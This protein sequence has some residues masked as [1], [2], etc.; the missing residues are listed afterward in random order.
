M[1]T[2]GSPLRLLS[3]IPGLVRLSNDYAHASELASDDLSR[4]VRQLRSADVVVIDDDSRKLMVAALLRPFSRFRLVSVDLVLRRP[5]SL[6]SA[7]SGR[8]KR[9]LLRQVDRFVL[10]FRNVGPF[11]TAYGIAPARTAYVPF[12]VN[13]WEQR[14]DWPAPV[15]PGDY[16]LCAGRSQR[17]VNTFIKA[18]SLVGCP[19]V[20]ANGTPEV[21]TPLPPNVH[22]VIDPTD[23]LLS[24]LAHMARARII[25]IPRFR[26][27]LVASGIST[28]LMAMALG[29]PVILSSGP[30]AEDVLQGEA[31]IVPAEDVDSLA[32][33]IR[34][35]WSDDKARRE[36]SERG[37]RYADSLGGAARLQADV[38]RASLET[39]E[40]RS[41]AK[42]E[43]G[44][45]QHGLYPRGERSRS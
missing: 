35:L 27:D 45:T 3:N 10:Y 21:A 23:S 39:L 37:R 42:P 36:L 16:V 40:P 33:T 13:G 15:D 32:E 44:Q 2:A 11:S 6:P 8:I 4:F 38:L 5:G 9:L 25:V 7:L 43:A 12:K 14:A 34:R 29:K 18:M 20:V 19:G 26:G 22:L 31:A 17:D 41:T 24:F 28:Y 30:G 1:T